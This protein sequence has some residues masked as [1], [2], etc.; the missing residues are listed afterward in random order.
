MMSDMDMPKSKSSTLALFR[1]DVYS[2]AVQLQDRLMALQSNMQDRDSIRE[3]IRVAYLIKGISL[4][5]H[6][7]SVIKL[8]AA[9]GDYFQMVE[10]IY[11]TFEIKDFSLFFK[12]VEQFK[13][14][15]QWDDVVL[16]ERVNQPEEECDRISRAISDLIQKRKT[17]EEEPLS[18]AKAHP[19]E[20]FI[21]FEMGSIPTITDLFKIELEN[22]AKVLT[23]G[24]VSL[25][26]EENVSEH[27]EAMLRAVHSIKGAARIVRMNSIIQLAHVLEDCFVA[28]QKK[29][30]SLNKSD[31]DILLK[32]VDVFELLSKLS[33]DL[34]VNWLEQNKS[35]IKKLI[36][37][38]S[39]MSSQISFLQMEAEPRV[40]EK[41]NK[42]VS[43]ALQEKVIRVSAKSLSSLMELAGESLVESR[44]LYPFSESMFKLKK[45]FYELSCLIE[46]L[47]HLLEQKKIGA[48]EKNCL[49]LLHE[50]S[51]ECREYLNKRIA[52]LSNYIGRHTTLV[53]N[54]YH[55]VINSRMRPFAD[56]VEGFPRMVRDLAQQLHKKVRLEITGKMTP[57][58]RDILEILEA[59]LAHLI[60]NAV[61]HGIESP[62]LRI[63]LGKPAEGLIRLEAQHQAGM[64]VI[65]VFDD[66]VGVDMEAIRKKVVDRQLMDP[67][68]AAKLT[69]A[70]LAEFLF[71]SGFSTTTQVSEI[72]GRGIG[73]NA[74]QNMIHAV[75][76]KIQPV[77]TPGKGISFNLLLPLT[78][79]VKHCL[80]V[81]ISHETYAFPLAG[82]E[83]VVL[84]RSEKVETIENRKY[85]LHEGQNIGL[86]PA[87]QILGLKESVITSP[88]VPVIIVKDR[89]NVFGVVVDQFLGEKEL[90]VQELDSRL[91]KI[92]D[93]SAGAIMENGTPVLI[94]DTEGIVNT[95][96]NVAA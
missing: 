40:Q 37:D 68:K 52:D 27:L 15:G 54:L 9:F 42:K 87:W 74:V 84:L 58:D 76:G 67:E 69:D 31:I 90:V 39:A 11:P 10:E 64:L 30:I 34:V 45:N 66:G 2:Y 47:D 75:S 73:L 81:E 86:V 43:V 19:V 96:N 1:S 13:L 93:I 48:S 95:A 24:I 94:I 57:V 83:Q 35:L 29:T 25:E 63:A 36:A 46:E 23:N 82:I 18:I 14:I 4:I 53:D 78:I 33:Q 8:A 61:D 5:I 26:R 65:S 77:I 88:A 60:R 32:A 80:V 89:K 21:E 55:E 17:I 79:S 91:G 16:A 62:E 72:S 70:E 3:L 28:A 56:V 44:R 7:D 41:E 51:N 50:K 6:Y 49:E 38:I 71:L 59:P 12:A 20:P 92:R 22:Q 85:F